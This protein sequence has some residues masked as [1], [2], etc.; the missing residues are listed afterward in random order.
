[1]K[2]TLP[3]M[4]TIDIDNIPSDIRERVQKA[5]G[6]FTEGTNPD[7]MYHDQLYFIDICVERL[8]KSDEDDDVDDMILDWV[9]Y[10]LHEQG[11]LPD[12]GEVFGY[13]GLIQAYRVGKRKHEMYSHEYGT[14]KHDDDKCM[15]LLIEIIK[16]VM[17]YE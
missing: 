5:F 6:E 7:Y 14:A 15:K 4:E 8:H 13:D 16:A 10:E 17:S 2:V 9:K 3:R 12:N 1:M 11:Q